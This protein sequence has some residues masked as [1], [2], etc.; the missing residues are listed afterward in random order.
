MT[1]QHHHFITSI[2]A[3]KEQD[4]TTA[5]QEMKAAHQ[6][7]PSHPVFHYAS[8]YLEQL[9]PSSKTQVYESGSAFAAF[10]RGGG[11]I[12]LYKS[13]THAL[14][15]VYPKEPPARLLDI[16]VGDG[17]ALLPA[18]PHDLTHLDVLEPSAPMLQTTCDALAQQE[19]P[20]QPWNL[21]LKEFIHKAPS[22]ARW[23]LCQATFSLQSIEPK[24]RVEQLAWVRSRSSR[25]VL[26]E[27]DVPTFSEMW[28]EDRILHVLARYEQGLSEYTDTQD[29]VALGFLI[30]VM[31]GYFDPTQ[32][33]TNYEHT[34]EEWESQ[35][36]EAGYTTIHKTHLYPY[37]WADA[38]LLEASL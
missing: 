1:P 19:V 31:L 33:R 24:E 2:R 20:F 35:L 9:Q 32:A 7:E 27:F 28:G 34:I 17:M 12:E 26:A 29:E 4:L 25:L 18:L 36:R 22:D 14:Q 5:A 6:V 13:L 3:F 21:T 15:E 30:P 38:Y 10:I 16:G 37:W 8:L 23:D 11:N